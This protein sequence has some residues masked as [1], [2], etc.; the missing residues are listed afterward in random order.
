MTT[1][2]EDLPRPKPPQRHLSIH[3]LRPV[4]SAR[5]K[6]LASSK[7]PEE[8]VA[9]IQDE[10]GVDQDSAEQFVAWLRG[11][12]LSEPPSKGAIERVHVSTDPETGE[13]RYVE[14]QPGSIPP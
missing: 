8:A 10:Y 5:H 6:M 14:T 7:P 9:L 11:A 12:P 1:P 4:V 13:E 2:P 3:E